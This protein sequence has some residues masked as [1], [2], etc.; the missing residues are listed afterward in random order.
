MVLR[1]QINA[2]QKLSSTTLTQVETF[3]TEHSEFLKTTG[4]VTAAI[5]VGAAGGYL[6]AKGVWVAKGAA[7]AKTAT[8]APLATQGATGGAATMQNTVALLNNSIAGGTALVDKFSAL[9][10]TLSTNAVPLT[11]GVVGGGAAGVGATRYQVQRVKNEL[12]EQAAQTAVAQAE[13]V[14]LE[15]ALATANA[16][17][18]E[19]QSKQA[20]Q[21]APPIIQ[22]RL[23][24]IK[25]IGRVFAQRLNAAG[26]STLAD[27]AAQTPERLQEIIGTSRAATMVQPADWIQQA[28]HLLHAEEAMPAVRTADAPPDRVEEATTSR[29]SDRLEAIRGIT[30]AI[31]ARLNQ[32]DILT[33]VDL[34]GQTT[35]RLQELFDAEGQLPES[36]LAEWIITARTLA[37]Q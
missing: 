15:N 37:T 18:A 23:E 14:Y 20:A 6:L 21:A 4:I 24:Q 22:E 30:P 19:L 17:L 2:L 29:L 16:N 7:A 35:D 32:A 36:T 9:F 11:A 8:V 12:N 25:G 10:N 3:A 28:R 33:Y 13:K 34:A 27:L 31:A 5:L 26:I 1:E